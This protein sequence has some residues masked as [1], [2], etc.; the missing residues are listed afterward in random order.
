MGTGDARLPDP[1]RRGARLKLLVVSGRLEDHLPRSGRW[2]QSPW[3]DITAPPA[4][5]TAS[6]A[7]PQV[8]SAVRC[9]ATRTWS[10]VGANVA[11]AVVPTTGQLSAASCP[12]TYVQSAG[13]PGGLNQRP[14]IEP[15]F[16]TAR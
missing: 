16:A 13:V 6:V 2:H 9:V 12:I 8:A 4:S 3:S 14:S 15:Q 11:L 1:P 5:V 7:V 10:V